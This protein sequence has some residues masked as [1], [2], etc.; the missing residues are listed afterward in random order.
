M[1]SIAGTLWYYLIKL[2]FYGKRHSTEKERIDGIF[3][4]Y[5]LQT[6]PQKIPSAARAEPS[7]LV[8]ENVF[9]NPSCGEEWQNF[10][11]IP[12]A[13]DTTKKVVIY[14]H[15]GGFVL[16]VSVSEGDVQALMSQA[17]PLEWK[18]P[19]RI[20]REHRLPVFFPHWGLAPLSTALTFAETV[21]EY[22]LSVAADPRFAGREIVLVGSSA[23][24]WCALRSLL[25]LC[26]AHGAG[27]LR[28]QDALARIHQIILVAPVVSP[29]MDERAK[30]VST[31]VSKGRRRH[32]IIAGSLSG[33]RACEVDGKPMGVW[34]GCLSDAPRQAARI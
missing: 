18:V 6:G 28:V 12:E 24:G 13:F 22:V 20:A 5:L 25:A 19:M 17:H 7:V 33:R 21:V 14:F 16:A 27:Q 23:G 3:D 2:A 29:V 4:G 9:R 10:E 26:E 8:T 30:E 32:L 31:R 11:F 15:G 34:T 1:P